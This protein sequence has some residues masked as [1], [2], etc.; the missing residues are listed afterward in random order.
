MQYKK[1]EAR[2]NSSFS[3]K[4]SEAWASYISYSTCLSVIISSNTF[5][6]LIFHLLFAGHFF[7]GPVGYGG[8]QT[9]RLTKFSLVNS[10]NDE[11]HLVIMTRKGEIFRH[12]VWKVSS[13]TM[14]PNV[15]F[16]SLGH[17]I[18]MFRCSIIKLSV[19]WQAVLVLN[20]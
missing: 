3:C 1:K 9:K 17:K 11:I 12:S 10:M 7:G 16:L 8:L 14:N 18:K 20:L 5:F 6:L 19:D 15:R 13:V 4:N 2:T